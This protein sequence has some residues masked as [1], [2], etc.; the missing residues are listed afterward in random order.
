[1]EQ[2]PGGFKVIT[3]FFIPDNP[4]TLIKAFLDVLTAVGFLALLI[5][6]FL[7]KA[8]Y[9]VIERKG[10]IPLVGFAFMGLI[11]TAM[12]AFDEFYWFDSKAFYDQIWK[13][14]RLYIF[15]IAIFLLLLTFYQFYQ[16]SDR[17]FG[18]ESS[19]GNK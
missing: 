4:L 1:M 2:K 8:R 15:I 10:F 3:D 12:D 17:L 19:R 9:P 13:P 16:F 7:A 5:V 11:S 18:E 6:V 14:A